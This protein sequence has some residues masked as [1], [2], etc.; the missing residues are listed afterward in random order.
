MG[1]PAHGWT[2]SIR[3]RL[4]AVPWAGPRGAAQAHTPT[5]VFLPKLLCTV[6]QKKGSTQA[7]ICPDS[8][9]GTGILCWVRVTT[10][11]GRMTGV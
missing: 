7:E 6:S 11:P 1:A 2:L 3:T 8:S 4:T 10:H 5:F 9:E